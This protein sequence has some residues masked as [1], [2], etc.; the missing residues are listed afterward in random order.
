MLARPQWLLLLAAACSPPLTTRYAVV[1]PT[2]HQAISLLGDTLW[3]LPLDPKQG[4][5]LVEQLQIARNRNAMEVP[6]V[7]DQLLL[8][9][10]TAEMGRLREALIL[11]SR[12]AQVHFN[13]PRVFRE[14]GEILLILREFAAAREDFQKAGAL[15]IGRNGLA[16]LTDL[17]EGGAQLTTVQFQT[18]LYLG[19]THYLLGNWVASRDVL[20]EAVKEAANDDDVAL[21]AVW[22]FFA[23]RRIGTGAAAAEILRALGPNLEVRLSRHEYDLLQAYRGQ[24][25]SDSIN[26]RATSREGGDERALYAYGIGMWH[27]VRGQAA[28]A[29]TWFEYARRIPNWATLPYIAAEAELLRLRKKS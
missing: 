17:P 1:G 4:P 7:Q 14:R 10:R 8:A 26:S 2:S 28:D 5:R 22:L 23:A 18:A 21:A 12:T 25:P 13:N 11:L 3:T 6:P 9:R 19:V 24:V 20:I 29:E 27:L 16:E 15:M